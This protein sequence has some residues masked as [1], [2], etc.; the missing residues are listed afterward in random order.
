MSKHRAVFLDRD[1][2]ICEEVGYLN[3]VH[4]MRLIPRS[5]E[6]IRRLN[7]HG[8]KVVVITNQSGVARGLILEQNLNDIHTE[9]IRQLREEGAS[10]DGIY[11]CPHHPTEGNPPYLQECTCRKPATGLLKKAA[12]DLNLDL[13]SSYMVGDHFSDIECGRRVGAKTVLLLTGHGRQALERQGEWPSQ[14]DYLAADLY[15]AVNWI[16][17]Q[18]YKTIA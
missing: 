11:Y 1:G 17:Q 8:F 12:A 6:A 4:Q 2:T 9:M 7:E 16:L 14:P 13:S 3:S 15:E 18:E 10:L 5:A